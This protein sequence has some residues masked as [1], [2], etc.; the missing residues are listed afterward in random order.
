MRYKSL[1]VP[2][3]RDGD[4]IIVSAMYGEIT[5]HHES[6]AHEEDPVTGKTYRADAPLYADPGCTVPVTRETLPD[7]YLGLTDW[8]LP[9][10]RLVQDWHD[11]PAAER[12]TAQASW[13]VQ[14][15]KLKTEAVI[16]RRASSQGEK[17]GAPAGMAPPVTSAVRQT[18]STARS[19]ADHPQEH[20]ASKGTET[21]S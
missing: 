1:A 2:K 14:G 5:G 19:T 13:G 6:R 15:N 20:G 18:G 4:V 8:V 16:R 12:A 21:R 10:G 17:P 11:V 3:L 9:G 7:V